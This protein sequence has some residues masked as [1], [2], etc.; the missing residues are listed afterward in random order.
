MRG[1]LFTLLSVLSLLA[2]VVM[3]ALWVRSYRVSDLVG[4]KV[5]SGAI[6]GLMLYR[7]SIGFVSIQEPARRPGERRYGYAGTATRRWDE[8][9][10]SPSVTNVAGFHYISIPG[11]F[12]FTLVPIW[13]PLALLAILPA[14]MALRHRRDRDRCKT[15]VCPRCGYDLR[16]TPDRCPECGEIIRHESG[17]VT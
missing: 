13:L 4:Y 17:R 6:R 7:G 5:D 1:H 2:C 14:R 16:A 10:L 11:R 8:L 3:C 15:G 9:V 12:G